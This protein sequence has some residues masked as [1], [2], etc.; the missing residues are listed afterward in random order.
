MLDKEFFLAQQL[1]NKNLTPVDLQNKNISKKRLFSIAYAYYLLGLT[2]KNTKE[3]YQIVIDHFIQFMLNIKNSTP[4]ETNGID[5]SLWKDDLLRTGGVGGAFPNSNLDR[6][7]SHERTSVHNKIAILSAFFR[8]LQKPGMDGSPPLVAYNPVD[9]LHDKVKID[10]YGHSK[11]ITISVFRK[12]VEK[13]NTSTLK[14]LRDAALIYGYFIT[15]R[16][17][18][19]WVSLTWGQIN[20]NTVPPTYSFIRKG[21]KQTI[22][23]LPEKLEFLLMKYLSN[24][25]GEDFKEKLSSNSYLFTA[26]PGHGGSRQIVDPNFPL[27]ERS[28]LKIIK[29]YAKKAGVDPNKI[30]V[31]SLRHLHA[32][33]CL[34]AGASVEEVRARLCHESLATTQRY[35]SSM[36]NEKNRLAS[37]LDDLLANKPDPNIKIGPL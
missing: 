1:Q 25:W 34:A 17:N 14:G 4:L 32:E 22:D 5:V 2:N 29:Y 3:H 35:V 8:Y 9:A 20:F 18:S 26:M 23:E 30:T 6:F 7:V 21:Q 15:G 19:E 12:I 37:K 10:K 13:I 16:R 24:R 28:M 27:N 36:G 33:S 11:K 31:H